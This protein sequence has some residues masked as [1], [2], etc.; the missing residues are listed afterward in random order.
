MS[1]PDDIEDTTLD[2]EEAIEERLLAALDAEEATD[3]REEAEDK[4]EEAAAVLDAEDREEAEESYSTQMAKVSFSLSGRTEIL[5]DVPRGRSQAPGLATGSQSGRK[6]RGASN[7][8]YVRRWPLT[9]TDAELDAALAVTEA[10]EAVEAADEAAAEAE[11]ID[12][13][14]EE[15][16]PCPKTTAL[17][18]NN[19]NRKAMFAIAAKMEE[20]FTW[21]RTKREIGWIS[22]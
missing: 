18:R 4:A 22:V 11:L 19:R 21:K 6:T 7:P 1:L 13:A 15:E 17:N 9:A 2:A 20:D 16:A 8:R 10:W 3:E 14:A 5:Y 12:D